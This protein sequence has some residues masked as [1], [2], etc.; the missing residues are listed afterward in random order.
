MW[1]YWLYACRQNFDWL[2]ACFH[3]MIL[4]KMIKSFWTISKKYKQFIFVKMILQYKN[5]WSTLYIFKLDETQFRLNKI[6]KIKD[7]FLAEIWERKTM[8]KRLSKYIAAFDYFEK[9]F[10]YLQQVKEYLLLLFLVLLEL[11]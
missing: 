6:N 2:L 8:N 11:L 1:I 9:A 4:R 10:F 7:Y 5:G 3:L